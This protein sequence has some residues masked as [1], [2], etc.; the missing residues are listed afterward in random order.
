MV[1]HASHS[2]ADG[3]GWL[4]PMDNMQ[5]RKFPDGRWHRPIVVRYKPDVVLTVNQ[6][7]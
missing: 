3:V 6:L 7:L 1:V 2:A 5:V 4:W